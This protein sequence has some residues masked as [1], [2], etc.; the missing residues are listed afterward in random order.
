MPVQIVI[1]GKAHPKDH[2]G[3]MLIREIVQLS[4]DPSVSKRLVFLEDYGIEVARDMVQGVDLW[5]NNPRR[6]E[7]ACGTSGM[8]AGINGILNLSILDGWW[9]EAFE[10][11]AGWAIGERVPYSE[12]QDEYHASAIYSTL[13]NEI[14]PLYYSGRED[15]F[16]DQWVRRMKHCLMKISP[17]FN[18][19]RMVTEYMEH[20]YE[21][22]HKLYS[23]MRA[24]EFAA[25]RQL[26]GW[27]S[28]VQHAWPNIKFLELGPGPDASV[29][30]GSSIPMRAVLELAGLTPGDIRVEAVVGR[31]GVSG[32]LEET[33]VVTLPP[34][35]QRGS[36]FVFQREF[37]P[38]Q[39]GRL[40][41]ALRISP[42]HDDNP[43]TR[44]CDSLIKWG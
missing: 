12:D 23:E 6:G 26:A 43:L 24:N 36:A 34:V 33:E 11:S 15:G 10:E 28:G 30:S 42:N 7:E 4:R 21:P 20:L 14:V 29:L 3:K 1:A 17:R 35:E 25:A 38:H 18:C 16:P 32:K 44:P 39:T 9:D 8:K 13:E 40:G 5:L 19:Q 27:A 41:Y 22:A 37:I 2:P 31:V